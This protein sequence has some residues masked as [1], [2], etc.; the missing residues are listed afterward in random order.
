MMP[1]SNSAVATPASV[2]FVPPLAY[3]VAAA[4]FGAVTT[5]VF[6]TPLDVVKT[7]LQAPPVAGSA[8]MP[9]STFA[10]LAHLG[11]C[12]PP[13][14][15]VAASSFPLILPLIGATAGGVARACFP[16]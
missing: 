1:A 12:P 4:V 7:R 15:P 13:H 14:L 8:P 11:P 5:S 2:S 9:K 6:V 16:V 10:A 3:R